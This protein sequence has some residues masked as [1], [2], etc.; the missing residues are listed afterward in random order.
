MAMNLWR[1]WII[2]EETGSVYV[3]FSMCLFYLSPSSISWRRTDLQ[4]ERG[5]QSKQE[6]DCLN[7]HQLHC[8]DY[9]VIST[10]DYLS[11]HHFLKSY[12]VRYQCLGATL[13]NQIFTFFSIVTDNLFFF[14]K[15]KTTFESCFLRTEWVWLTP[16]SGKINV[17]C[18]RSL[19]TL[20][21]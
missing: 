11:S 17:K 21:K 4:H 13:W 6:R 7:H 10:T 12:T 16:S 8:S 1:N 18:A 20:H 14:F 9:F 15:P 2:P 3:F 19:I 5:P